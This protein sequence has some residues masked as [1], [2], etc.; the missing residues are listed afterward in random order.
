MQAL[1][2]PAIAG[3]LLLVVLI[4]A[5]ANYNVLITGL[6]DAPT[7]KMTYIL[8]AILFGSG[9]LGVLVAAGLRSSRP[10]IYRRIG[11][12]TEVEADEH[13]T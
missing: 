13:L 3:V 9:I 10:E 4:L 6:I 8:P 2:A 12:R 5:L 7:D 1:Y 11:E